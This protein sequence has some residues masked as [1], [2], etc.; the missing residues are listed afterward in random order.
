MSLQQQLALVSASAAKT[1]PTA[2]A[3]KPEPTKTGE[4]LKRDG[5][6]RAKSNAS[7]GWKRAF[8]NEAIIL[9]SYGVAFTAEDVTAKCGYPPA[10]SHPN[11]V[12]AMMGAVVKALKLTRCAYVKS[13]RPT[14]HSAIIAQWVK[15][16][17]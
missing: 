17:A 3:P 1:A 7:D 16:K 13:K 10:G 12:G 8:L 15:I 9:A 5:M 6:A 14:S 11:T 4:D 2:E